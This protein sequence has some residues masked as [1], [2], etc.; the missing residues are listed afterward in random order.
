[1]PY[2]VVQGNIGD[3]SKRAALAAKLTETVSWL[4][5]APKKNVVVVVQ[6]GMEEEIIASVDGREQA[7][8]LEVTVE[9]AGIDESEMA[10]A[11]QDV[12]A[13]AADATGLDAGRIMVLVK[14]PGGPHMKMTSRCCGIGGKLLA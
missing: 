11:V 4:F 5:H 8:D 2:V 3:R 13:A 6:S 12:T 9:G 7:L 1:M 10:R 14:V